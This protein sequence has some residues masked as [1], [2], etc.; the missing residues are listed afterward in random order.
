MLK[1]HL[2][3]DLHNEITGENKRIEQDNM[4]TN[5]L[6][7]LLGLA[8]NVGGKGYD[9]F[10]DLLPAATYALGGLFLFDGRA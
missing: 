3:I 8:A 2:Q 10:D 1:G 9:H 6:G 5:A 7:D 4:V